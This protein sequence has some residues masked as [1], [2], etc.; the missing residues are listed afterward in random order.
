MSLDRRHWIGIIL[1]SLMLI[2]VLVVAIAVPLN[3]RNELAD[4]SASTSRELAMKYLSE[5]PLIDG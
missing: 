2:A 4:R 1:V 3:N 5:T